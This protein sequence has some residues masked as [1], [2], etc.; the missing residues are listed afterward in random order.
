MWISGGGVAKC[1]GD[2]ICESARSVNGFE[3]AGRKQSEA[4]REDR[5]DE[6]LARPSGRKS[7]EGAEFL[8]LVGGDSEPVGWRRALESPG[9]LEFL[10]ACIEFVPDRGDA[11][12]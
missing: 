10:L 8:A 2:P 9:R 1:S 11:K 4:F 7:D 3:E 12:I 5:N 6:P